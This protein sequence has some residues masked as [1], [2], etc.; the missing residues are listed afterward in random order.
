MLQR[1]DPTF[2]YY[3]SEV[4]F[5]DGD[6]VL[7]HWSSARNRHEVI[8][9][10]LSHRETDDIGLESVLS[11]WQGM[12]NQCVVSVGPGGS[13]TVVSQDGLIL[14]ANHVLDADSATTKIYFVDGRVLEANVLERS[15]RLDVA[16]LRI[17]VNR[18]IPFVE[19][20]RNPVDAG[21]PVWLIGYGGGRSDPLIREATTTRYVLDELITT[22]NNIIG[23]DS[24]GAVFDS[25]G[26]LAGVILG[27]GDIYKRTLRTLSTPAIRDL[28]SVLREEANQDGGDTGRAK[29]VSETDPSGDPLR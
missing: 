24:G 9:G 10:D 8:F 11:P 14:T 29:R 4:T 2:G 12:A 16:V 21:E 28:F 19:L 27:P 25:R 13:G 1:T 6:R 20:E 5:G 3:G 22:W 26:H 7:T 23:G 18:P 15:K 17:P